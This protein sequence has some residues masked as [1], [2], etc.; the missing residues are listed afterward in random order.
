MQQREVSTMTVRTLDN[1]PGGPFWFRKGDRV[2]WLRD[3]RSL[4]PERR[5]VIA[6]GVCEYQEGRTSYKE[7]YVVQLE[8]GP[9]VW[10]GPFDIVKVV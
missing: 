2:A 8:D 3:D 5:G 6:N 7:R 1:Y 4:D 9:P 10:A